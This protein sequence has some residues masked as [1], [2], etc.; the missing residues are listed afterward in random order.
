MTDDIRLRH[1]FPLRTAFG[2]NLRDA[3]FLKLETFGALRGS[4]LKERHLALERWK[5]PKR[6]EES[7]RKPRF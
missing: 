2:V 5:P 6:N 3:Y 1:V 4:L 7:A